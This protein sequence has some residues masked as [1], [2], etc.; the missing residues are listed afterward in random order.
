MSLNFKIK[1]SKNSLVVTCDLELTS[2][3]FIFFLLCVCINLS[4]E[5]LMTCK[6]YL[7]NCMFHVIS[8]KIGNTDILG[9]FFSGVENLSVSYSL[10]QLT[11]YDTGL[12]KLEAQFLM[13]HYY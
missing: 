11:R 13:H 6:Q 9:N 1:T 3:I 5:Y 12:V 4:K 10:S 2:L 7:Q 8:R